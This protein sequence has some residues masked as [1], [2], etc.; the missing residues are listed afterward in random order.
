MSQRT[1][2]F[3]RNACPDATWVYSPSGW[4]Y[5][6]SDGSYICWTSSMYD[7][8]GTGPAHLYRYFP[9]KDKTPEYL[10]GRRG[11]D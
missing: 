5:E 3:I 9:G 11:R 10:K 7:D 4:R 2:D 6:G 1:I 8:E